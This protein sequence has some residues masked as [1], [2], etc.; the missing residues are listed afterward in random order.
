MVLR[1]KKV[2]FAGVESEGMM[3][4][5]LEIGI[6]LEDFPN[7]IEEGIMILPSEYEVHIGKDAVEV[8][9]L[10]EDIIEFEITSNR[11]DCLSAEGLG[12]EVAA[13]LGK[14]FT[15]PNAALDG[16]VGAE[17][18]SARLRRRADMESAPTGYHRGT[19]LMS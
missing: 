19:Y 1:L 13:T 16:F 4:G 9:G 2:L 3:C 11:P 18:I 5:I 17:S 14:E 12:R 6:S 10:R 15:N 7:Q 8:L